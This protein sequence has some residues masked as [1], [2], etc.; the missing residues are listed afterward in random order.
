MISV[1]IIGGAGYTAGELLRILIHHPHVTIDFVHSSSNAGNPITK[2]HTD[3]LGDTSLTFSSSYHAS[4]DVVFFCSGHGATDKFLHDHPEFLKTKII[5]LS[6]D[7]R[8][9]QPSHDFVYGLPEMNKSQ[10]QKAKH[11][12]NPG[13]FATCIQL[14]ILP[15]ANAGK[16]IDDI[17]VNAITG[18]TGAGHQPT[19]TTHF[20]WRD[21]NVSV[22]KPFNHQHLK[23][24]IQSIKQLQ[25]YFHHRINFIPMRGPFTRGIM[26][27]MYTKTTLLSLSEAK[28]LYQEYYNDSPFVVISH[29]SPDLK[30]V[31]N[32]NKAI[33]YLEKHEDLLFAIVVIDNLL[34][35]ASGQAVQNMNLMFGLP[36]NSGLKLK[37]TAF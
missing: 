18:S 33:V 30:Q 35:G 25:P 14:G 2:V 16:L 37:P 22:Y 29:E 36:E 12:A 4:V 1:G 9:Y 6:Q 20:S 31:I 5:D 24:I 10:I 3:L 26:A 15:L 8:I 21:S 19:E 32:T 17:H 28:E 11:I 27:T 23:E 13:C 34:K 7:F